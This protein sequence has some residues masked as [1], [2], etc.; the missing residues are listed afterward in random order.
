M[1]LSRSEGTSSRPTDPAA[2]PKLSADE[3]AVDDKVRRMSNPVRCDHCG[4]ISVS[5]IL[6][7]PSVLVS[8]AQPPF[9]LSGSPSVDP[10]RCPICLR[11]LTKAQSQSHAL[12]EVIRQQELTH[13]EINLLV[14]TLRELMEE[15]ASGDVVNT[16]IQRRVPR[17]TPIFDRLPPGDVTGFLA[18]VV[19]SIALLNDLVANWLAPPQASSD[20]KDRAN[21]PVRLNEICQVIQPREGE[22]FA[23]DMEDGHP[24]FNTRVRITAE[25]YTLTIDGDEPGG[26]RST[27]I[28]NRQGVHDALVDYWAADFVLRSGMGLA[29]GRM[30][31]QMDA[32]GMMKVLVT[33][34]KGRRFS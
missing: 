24:R 21:P 12:A 5:G 10:G 29:L 32:I 14:D 2:T 28:A 25:G 7:P 26:T 13:K 6:I 3:E 23:K 19:A 16:R 22:V 8:D 33:F 31:I 11:S 9:D 27:L 34:P 4:S 17:A 18:L 15:R 20:S 1:G 30:P